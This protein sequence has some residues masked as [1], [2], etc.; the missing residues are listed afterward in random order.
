MSLKEDDCVKQI[1]LT[2]ASAGE[3]IIYKEKELYFQKIKLMSRDT[4]GV[5]VR[6]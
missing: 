2:D 3:H 1:Y 5:K 6:R 4:R